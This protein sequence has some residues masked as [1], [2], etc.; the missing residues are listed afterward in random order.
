MLA[1][2]EH[3]ENLFARLFSYSPRS[4]RNPL[5]DYCTEGLAW[6]LIQSPEFAAEFLKTIRGR[7]GRAANPQLANY[8]GALD[9]STQV[10][11]TGEDN[12]SGDGDDSR[13][14]RFDLVLRPAGS[15]DFIVI[16]E[17]KVGLDPKV[18][19]QAAKYKRQLKAHPQFSQVSEGERYVLTLT[20]A[21]GT[22]P[23][24]DAHLSWQGVYELLDSF[25]KSRPSTNPLKPW[26][27][28][29]A[30]FLK[31]S[32]IA[33]VKLP[34]LDSATI[35]NFQ[36]I[37]PFLA[38]AK[39]HFGAFA[40]DDVLKKFFRKRDAEHPTVAFDE[41]DRNVWY[42]IQC[43]KEQ[44]YAYAALVFRGK[45][46]A[47]F[48]QVTYTS[49]LTDRH[50]TMKG[51]LLEAATAATDFYGSNFE[52]EGKELSIY[53]VRRHVEGGTSE[54]TPWFRKIF[55]EISKHFEG[56]ARRG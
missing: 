5:E 4:E 16:L 6:L 12:E 10:S 14:G 15:D 19:A 36:K 1:A 56:P 2:D 43:I 55:D 13:G 46:I 3:A 51:E 33:L 38:V 54:V 49:D 17:S 25:S 11:Y 39:E 9:V 31:T 24:A 37:G 29:F 18:G 52:R 28:H 26:C 40:V 42:C 45:E 53:F 8:S 47:F 20:P 48:A 7:L 34:I 27:K 50:R 23:G 41:G 35:Q 32:H 44:R 30:D 21:S 22:P